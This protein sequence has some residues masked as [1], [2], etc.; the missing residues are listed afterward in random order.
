MQIENTQRGFGRGEFK[1]LYGDECS[2]Q[3]SSLATEDAIWLG[4]SKAKPIIMASKVVEGGTGWVDYPI[5]EDVFIGTR[6][7]L[8]QELAKELI[9][10]LQNFVD[11]GDLLYVQGSE[12]NG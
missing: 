8:N 2:I 12:E 11:T 4:I 7:H 5:H 1:D 9:L 10:Q 6:M 3:K